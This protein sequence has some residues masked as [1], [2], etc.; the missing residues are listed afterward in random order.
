MLV[1]LCE[2]HRILQYEFSMNLTSFCLISNYL[3]EQS[4]HIEQYLIKIIMENRSDALCFLP[5]PSLQAGAFGQEIP[6]VAA[7]L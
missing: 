6:F 7:L 5:I 2:S 3:T 1:K 4:N